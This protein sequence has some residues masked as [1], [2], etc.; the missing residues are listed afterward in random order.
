MKKSSVE[1]TMP[2]VPASFFALVD[3]PDPG[4]PR[5]RIIVLLL[6]SLTYFTYLSFYMW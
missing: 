5:I 2:S 1:Y 4:T 3:F 6:V